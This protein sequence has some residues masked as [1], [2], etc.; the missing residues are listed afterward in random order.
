[1]IRI[2]VNDQFTPTLKSIFRAKEKEAFKIFEFYAVEAVK[3]FL[4]AQGG[5]RFW[6]NRTFKALRSFIANAFVRENEIVLR[7]AYDGTA[8]NKYSNEEYTKYLETMQGGRF[9]ALPSIIEAIA[10]MLIRDIKLLY[11]DET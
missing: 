10:P 11:G 6:T 9:A 4:L 7:F 3:Y 5:N 8:I 1:M 2:I